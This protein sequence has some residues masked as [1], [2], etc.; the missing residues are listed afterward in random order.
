MID[1]RFD[2]GDHLMHRR[3]VGRVKERELRGAARVSGLRSGRLRECLRRS[4]ALVRAL[5]G[6]NA[7]LSWPDGRIR[8]PGA[9][10][11]PGGSS[12]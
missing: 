4:T 3:A 10:I 2:R 9:Q 8:A 5:R 6:F 1:L 7:R 11:A 12:T